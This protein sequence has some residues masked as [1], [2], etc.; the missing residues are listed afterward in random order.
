[1]ARMVDPSEI[2]VVSPVDAVIEDVGPINQTSEIIVKGK[3]Y[4][5]VEMLGSQET[6]NKYLH[7][8]Y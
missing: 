5:I 3:T 7:G 1:E 6:A 8:T 4:S 2:T